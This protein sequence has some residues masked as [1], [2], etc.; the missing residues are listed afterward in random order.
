MQKCEKKI[1]QGTFFLAV[2][3]FAV[4]KRA[5]TVSTFVFLSKGRSKM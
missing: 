5:K 2:F 1:C 3:L 4:M